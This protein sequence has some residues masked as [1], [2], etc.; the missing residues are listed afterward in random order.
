MLTR[1]TVILIDEN[2]QYRV[3]FA[4]LLRDNL[5]EVLL[6]SNREKIDF[7][8][9]SKMNPE[10]AIVDFK[11]TQKDSLEIAVKFRSMFPDAKIIFQS[12]YLPVFFLS[13]LNEVGD[14]LIVKMKLNA[15]DCLELIEKVTKAPPVESKSGDS[16]K[17]H[18]QLMGKESE[19]FGNVISEERLAANS[20]RQL[21]I[22]CLRMLP[23]ESTIM[24]TPKA[25]EFISAIFSEIKPGGSSSDKSN[26]I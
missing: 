16:K 24:L 10:V 26:S 8:S 3:M 19:I 4:K 22:E 11:T 9:L 13:K 6:S 18:F 15:K 23:E 5:F 21:L 7:E 1:T 17:K 25:T 12:I 20:K 2:E 14:G